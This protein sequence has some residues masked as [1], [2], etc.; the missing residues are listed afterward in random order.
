MSTSGRPGTYPQVSRPALINRAR[1]HLTSTSRNTEK[2]GDCPWAGGI[3]RDVNAWSGRYSVLRRHEPHRY[4]GRL[5]S[6]VGCVHVA[7]Q[8]RGV[9]SASGTVALDDIDSECV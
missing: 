9:V 5:C 4:A 2:R 3:P 7:A 6:A 1:L 8:L